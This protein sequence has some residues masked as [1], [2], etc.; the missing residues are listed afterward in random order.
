[1][2]NFDP[3]SPTQPAGSAPAA[4]TPASPAAETPQPA[5]ANDRP[6]QASTFDPFNAP[7]GTTSTE[8]LPALPEIAEGKFVREDLGGGQSRFG[9]V[10][11]AATLENDP[12]RTG[13]RHAVVVAWFDHVSQPILTDQLQVL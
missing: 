10:I 2:S 13:P 5:T 4:S 3:F 6:A 9:V 11:K 8:K 12:N 7:Q 1:M